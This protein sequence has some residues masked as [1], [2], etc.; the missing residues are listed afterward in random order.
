MKSP[1]LPLFVEQAPFAVALFDREMRCVAA[2]PRWM[3]EHELDSSIIG[4]NAGV[5]DPDTAA[6]LGKSFGLALAGETIIRPADCLT[7][8]SGATRRVRTEI[9]PWRPQDD[10]IRGIVVFVE[11]ITDQFQRFLTERAGREVD[12]TF[13]AT[14]AH[15]LR[16][17]LATINLTIEQLYASL[18]YDRPELRSALERAQ[19]QGRR[20]DRLINELAELASVIQNRIDLRKQ[21]VDLTPLVQEAVD[22]VRGRVA[23]R[24]C[25]LVLR[26]PNGPLLILADP[27]KMMQTFRVLLD[28][29][30]KFTARGI[31]VDV[32]HT[33]TT[34]IVAVRNDGADIPAEQI[35]A[36]FDPFRQ[37]QSH[38][39]ADGLG[40]GLALARHWLRLHGGELEARSDG[41]REGSLFVARLPLHHG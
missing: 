23:E 32:S 13:L 21:R 19:R 22:M 28:N 20:L 5:V 11:D 31:E 16:N 17:P 10:A 29:A 38:R 41:L 2:S 14:V 15:D 26:L 4:K 9:R 33:E 3:T 36:I 7:L 37:R 8:P 6:W 35:E 34:A 18:Q 27:Q 24:A 30:A 12:G 1:D 25:E 39:K 40:V